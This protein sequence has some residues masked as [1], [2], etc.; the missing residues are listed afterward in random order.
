MVEFK[1]K[2]IANELMVHAAAVLVLFLARSAA[3]GTAPA[4]ATQPLQLLTG[5]PQARCMDGTAS[6]FYLHKSRLG[7]AQTKW[8]LTLQGGGEC[9]SVRCASKA[10][11]ALGSSN[12]FPKSF[13]FWNEA[14]TH[15]ADTSCAGNPELCDYNQVPSTL[16]AVRRP[17]RLAL[18]AAFAFVLTPPTHTLTHTPHHNPMPPPPPGVPALLLAGSLDGPGQLHVARKLHRARLVLLGPPH[19]ECCAG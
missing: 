15:L 10:K 7:A 11:S 17:S 4:N 2:G 19:P 16:N 6:G 9:V 3:L 1:F 5:Y 13:E 8:V 12:Y 18:R 14:N